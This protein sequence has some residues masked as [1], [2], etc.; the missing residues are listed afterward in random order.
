MSS[1]NKAE[2]LS[3]SGRAAPRLLVHGLAV[4]E[5]VAVARGLRD[6]PWSITEISAPEDLLTALERPGPVAALV[7]AD[8]IANGAVPDNAD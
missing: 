7:N 8:R 6:D 3:L 5:L 4:G 2:N 1:A